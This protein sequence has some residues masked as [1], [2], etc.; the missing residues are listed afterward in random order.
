MPQRSK[1]TIKYYQVKLKKEKKKR[2]GLKNH[3]PRQTWYTW[4]ELGSQ[5]GEGAELELG[6]G[7]GSKLR[8]GEGLESKDEGSEIGEGKGSEIGECEGSELESRIDGRMLSNRRWLG[9]RIDASKSS[10]MGSY[11]Q[12][13]SLTVM[14]GLLSVMV[15]NGFLL[16]AL[17]WI[18]WE[19]HQ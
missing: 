9:V 14:N 10:R 8:E 1:S 6:E 17:V 15:G 12:R 5:I 18:F 7:E 4:Q 3:S 2:I 19:W 16:P 13:F 11:R